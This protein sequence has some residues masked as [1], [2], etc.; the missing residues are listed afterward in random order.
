MGLRLRYWREITGL[1]SAE[2]ARAVDVT[3]CAVSLWES[4]KR[5]IPQPMLAR[6]CEVLGISMAQFWSRG[7]TLPERVEPDAE[8]T[9]GKD[10]CER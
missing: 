5:N 3:R 7:I 6:V 8:A 10:G 4:G 2:L 9:G 1:R